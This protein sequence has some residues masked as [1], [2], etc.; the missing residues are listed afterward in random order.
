MFQRLICISAVLF[1]TLVPSLAAQV[2]SATKKAEAGKAAPSFI[3]LVRD[4]DGEPTAL[5]TAVVRYRPAVGKAD[6]TVDLVGVVHIGESSY[7][8][9]LNKLLG[10]YDAVL[11]ELVAPPGT[12]IPKGGRQ[13]DNPLAWIQKIATVILD[14]ESQTEKIDYA[15]KHFVHADMSP[16]QM[17]EAMRKRGDDGLTLALGI[18]A[19]VMRQQNLMEKKRQDTTDESLPDFS[20][21]LSDPTA[22][23]KLKRMLAGQLAALDDPAGGLGRTLQTLLITDRNQAALKVLDK[24]M[25]KGKKNIAIFY[26]AGHMPDFDQ[27]LRTAYGLVPVQ[28]TWLHAWDLRLHERSIEEL[29][30]RV[31]M[32]K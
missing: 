22:P 27:R 29:L 7:Y 6:L 31:L 25:A 23:S 9:K 5:E 26:G 21:L 18:L 15:A 16:E 32:R 24:E 2:P 19:D 28:T 14:L 4:D 20:T 13:D 17:A 8:R 30:F 1:V 3:R 11:Y 12:V 10:Q